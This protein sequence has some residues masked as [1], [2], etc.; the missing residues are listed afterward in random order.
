ML[1]LVLTGIQGLHWGGL[2]V[3]KWRLPNLRITEF[4]NSIRW[5]LSSS[6]T[7]V[8]LLVCPSVVAFIRVPT[9]DD[10]A[11]WRAVVELRVRTAPKMVHRIRRW[12]VKRGN[13]GLRMRRVQLRPFFGRMNT[14]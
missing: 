5:K 6:K 3:L 9:W 14:M 11:H 1:I 12:V 13:E 4:G 10:L 7:G 2:G 8:D